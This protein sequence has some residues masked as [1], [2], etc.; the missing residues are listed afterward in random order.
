[1]ADFNKALEEVL[2]NEGQYSNDPDDPG[3]ETYKGIARNRNSE[4]Q[5]WIRIDLLRIESGFPDNLLTD[6]NLDYL[7]RSLYQV[8]YWH[9]IQ[10]DQIKEQRIGE[11]IFDFAVN[12][13][14]ITTARLV[15]LVS[16]AVI[17]GV[18]GEK[19]ITKLNEMDSDLFISQFA[20][21]KLA[22]YISICKKRPKSRKYFYGWCR[23]ILENI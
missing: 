10:G 15:Q 14:V 8:H 2:K 3:G 6:T 19:T 13:G 1:M 23:R 4:W 5:G 11:T 20:L 9:K 22:R 16:G 12:A 18:I 7:V 21:S 17:D